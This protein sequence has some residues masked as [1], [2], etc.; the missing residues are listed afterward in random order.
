M[1]GNIRNKEQ[2][3]IHF[4]FTLQREA[5]NSIITEDDADT[6]IV[7]TVIIKRNEHKVVIVEKYVDPLVLLITLTPLNIDIFFLK[8]ALKYP[9]TLLQFTRLAAITSSSKFQGVGFIS[10]RNERLR[11]YI[12]ISRKRKAYCGQVL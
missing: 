1:V 8:N 4:V 9:E 11:H 2:F 6:L 7:R 5:I 10:P 12:V 3:I